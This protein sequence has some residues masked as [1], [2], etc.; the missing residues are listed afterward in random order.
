VLRITDEQ[1]DLIRKHVPEQHYPDDCPGRKP[2]PERKVLETVRWTRNPGAQRHRFPQCYPNYET[3]PRGLQQW[4]Q[5]E[6]TRA[7]PTDL[8]NALGKE[9]GVNE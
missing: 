5:N 4:C 2:I 9:A 7:A 3:V 1:W 6:V 8:A